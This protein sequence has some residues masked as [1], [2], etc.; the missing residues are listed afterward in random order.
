LFPGEKQ[1]CLQ[2]FSEEATRYAAGKF[3][4]FNASHRGSGMPLWDGLVPR[5]RILRHHWKAACI[6]RQ[7]LPLTRRVEVVARRYGRV[8]NDAAESGP[9]AQAHPKAAFRTR[10]AS[11]KRAEFPCRVRV[12]LLR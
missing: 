1:K 12:A 2:S 5:S 8:S 3:A 6:T 11:I 10:G 9:A 7:L 4:R